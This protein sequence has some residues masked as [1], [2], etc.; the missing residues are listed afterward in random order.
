MVHNNI[1]QN[2]VLKYTK[3]K[4]SFEIIMIMSLIKNT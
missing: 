3:I 2:I 4:Y 1:L